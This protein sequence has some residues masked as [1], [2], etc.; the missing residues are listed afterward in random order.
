MCG[1]LAF[2]VMV[3]WQTFAIPVSPMYS[4]VGPTVFPM[5]TAAGLCLFGVLLG[6]RRSRRLAARGRE[7]GP[8]RL[9]GARFVVAGLIANVSLIGTLGFSLASTILF[10]LRPRGFGDEGDRARCGDR[11]AHLARGLFRLR[12][13]ARHQYRRR[14]ISRT[15]SIASLGQAEASHGH[16]LPARQRLRR[17][18]HADQPDVGLVGSTLGTAIGVLPGIGPALDGRAAAAHHRQGRADRGRSSCSPASTTAR[19]TAARPPRS[20]STRPAR[21]ATIVTALEGNKMAR[22]AA[23]APRW[24]PPPSARSSPARSAPCGITFLAP[25][26]VDFA[27]EV[28]PGRVFLAHGAGLRD[29]VAP[30]WAPHGAR[31][32]GAVPRALASA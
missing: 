22:A 21:R 20:C 28:R 4:K 13:D 19:C 31:H 15:R 29:G 16:P 32:D 30:C 1:L 5:I 7:G 12:Q 10:V 8:D 27:R 6:L 11:A 2:A 9:E 17:R 18:A 14:P 24:R 3:L 23:P 25:M 26:V